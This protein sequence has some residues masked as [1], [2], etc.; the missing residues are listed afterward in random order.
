[1][2]KRIQ[3]AIVALSALGL[4]LSSACTKDVPPGLK[5]VPADTDLVASVDAPALLGFAK[6]VAGKAVPA[7]M[8]AQIPTYEM[9]AQQAMQVGGLDLSRLTRLTALGSL[10]NPDD[11]AVIAEGLTAADVKGQPKGEHQGQPLFQVPAVGL[12]YAEL[13]GLG[14]VAAGSDAMLKKVVDTYLGKAPGIAGTE[15]GKV[16]ERLLDS[17][18]DYDQLRVYL[19][20]SSLP[21]MPIPVKMQGAGFF[22]HLDRGAAGVLLSDKQGAGDIAS[23]VNL[24]LMTVQAAL[25][26]GGGK[27]M[28]VELDKDTLKAV[29]D[30]LGKLRTEH[31]DDSVALNFAGDLKP[32][33]EKA[34]AVGIKEAR[35]DM[36]LPAGDDALPA[37]EEAPGDKPAAPSA[38]P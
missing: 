26:M 24:G 33:L 10:S 3:L 29:S 34:V 11:M 32:L 30:A 23:K 19:L 21:D 18:K 17:H 37:G 36:A 28:G 20:A 35:R 2:Q 12:T 5:A 25:T 7:D 8:K 31:K 14:L 22:L 13:K 38:T 9:L 4:V 16:L 6:Q 27:D 1:M 15:R